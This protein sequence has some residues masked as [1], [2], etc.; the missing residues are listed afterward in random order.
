[1][2]NRTSFA[3]LLLALLA[4]ACDDGPA[5]PDPGPSAQPEPLAPQLDA[6]LDRVVARG[7]VG[8]SLFV[9]RPGHETYFQARGSADLDASEALTPAHVFRI[10]SVS[11]TY[12]AVLM[13]KLAVEGRLSLDDRITQYLPADLAGLVPGAETISIY[14]LLTMWSGIAD[15]RDAAFSNEVIFGDHAKVRDEY[16]DLVDGLG[17][18]P[19]PCAPPELPPDQITPAIAS[20]LY[21]NANYVLAGYIVDKVLYGVDPAPGARPEHHAKAF[22]EQLF[23]PLGLTSTFYEKHLAPGESFVERLAHGYASVP[24]G[25]SG[26]MRVDVTGWDDGN[27][28]ANGGLV[29]TLDDVAAFR[30]AVFDPKRAYPM[31]SLDEKARLLDQLGAFNPI[32]VAPG[33]IMRNG[34]W[35]FSGDI[36][37]YTSWVQYSPASDT[38]IVFFSNDRD[39]EEP[40]FAVIDEIEALVASAAD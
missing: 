11:K 35:A 38:S 16:I 29:A 40:R 13:A 5:R 19:A 4:L 30:R 21:S 18:S 36:G 39:F 9:Q 34:Y 26:A 14:D 6:I 32:G 10:A 37:G 28:Y 27:G 33:G 24:P 1:M 8:V 3:A 2:L 20:C 17:R 15:Y 31:Q 7:T 25:Q 12:L 23:A 22:R